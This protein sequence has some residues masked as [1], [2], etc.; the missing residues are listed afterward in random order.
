MVT[1]LASGCGDCPYVSRVLAER[2]ADNSSS[3]HGGEAGRRIGIRTPPS[4]LGGTPR[5]G[6]RRATWLRQMGHTN[7]VEIEVVTFLLREQVNHLMG[8]CQPVTHASWHRV[9]LGPDDLVA[10][11]PPVLLQQLRYTFRCQKQTLGRR[12]LPRMVGVRIAE[13]EPEGARRDQHA[14][15]LACNGPNHFSPRLHICF[16]PYLAVSI[17]VT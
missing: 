4:F 7:R 9:W 2:M 5:C 17:I 12:A 11:Y 14:V 16:E 1:A 10:D 15:D 13:I 3:L 6:T 8:R